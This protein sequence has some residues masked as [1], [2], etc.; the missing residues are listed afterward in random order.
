[1]QTRKLPYL[2]GIIKWINTFTF[3][4]WTSSLMTR[5]GLFDES[6]NG[7]V[8][9]AISFILTQIIFT[10]VVGNLLE[11]KFGRE[12]LIENNKIFKI[13]SI[14]V[15]LSIAFYILFIRKEVKSFLFIITLVIIFSVVMRFMSKVR[16]GKVQPKREEF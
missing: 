5:A 14:G 9:L 10:F 16:G 6:I 13:I 11:N 4:M 2:L 1:M 15:M 8:S 12:N 3:L 7:Y